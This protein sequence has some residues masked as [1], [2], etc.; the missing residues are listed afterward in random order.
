L[1]SC[2]R[3]LLQTA[4]PSPLGPWSRLPSLSVNRSLLAKRVT[5]PEPGQLTPVQ[6]TA[7]PLES[8]ISRPSVLKGPYGHPEVDSF[9]ARLGKKVM[10][11]GCGARAAALIEVT[12]RAAAQIIDFIV[13]AAISVK[14]PLLIA[15]RTSLSYI[16]TGIIYLNGHRLHLVRGCGEMSSA[17]V[18]RCWRSSISSNKT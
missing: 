7:S 1:Q 6:V 4:T 17:K 10:S 15:R 2:R 16:P 8:T 13:N 3:S 18:S 11:F 5:V 12:A 9:A 14:Q